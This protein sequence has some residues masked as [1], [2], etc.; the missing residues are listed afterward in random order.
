MRR[1]SAHIAVLS[2]LALPAWGQPDPGEALYGLGRQL[3]SEGKTAQALQKL[4]ESVRVSPK[5]PF[6]DDALLAAASIDYPPVGLN[7]LGR[8]TASGIPKARTRLE[9]IAKTYPDSSAAPA[10]M[11]RLGL[12]EM[13][14]V[15]P[16]ASLDEAYAT[17][18]QVGRLYP[19]SPEAAEAIYAA[20]TC[21]LLQG[22]RDAAAGEDARLV[23][24]HASGAAGE[25]ARLR[26]ATSA[27]RRGEMALAHRL[28]GPLLEDEIATTGS[29]NE[30][31]RTAS[32][33]RGAESTRAASVVRA[34]QLEYLFLRAAEDRPDRMGSR[35]LD[36]AFGAKSTAGESLAIA[37]GRDGRVWTLDD[38]SGRVAPLGGGG[39]QGASASA[40]GTTFAER[41][42][43][44][45]FDGRGA[46]VGWDEK[47][48][49]TR[50][51]QRLELIGPPARTDASGEPLRKI[52]AVAFGPFG[53]IDV[54]DGGETRVLRYGPDRAL[55]GVA[56]VLEGR[57][58]ALVRT[59][60]GTDYVLVAS[61]REV[62]VIPPA[63]APP[64]RRAVLPLKGP[65]WEL[66]SPAGLSVDPLGRI[67]VLDASSKSIAILDEQGRRVASIAPARG[68]PAE[69]KSPTAIAVDAAGYVYV[70]DRKPAR[71]VRF[72]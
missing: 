22:S 65:G 18:L 20:G 67:Y 19:R 70:A 10:A 2:L 66:G 3:L 27:A 4:E 34:K 37:V 63:G 46:L 48:L 24:E 49:L 5:G 6:A 52:T 15:N 14:P 35:V 60:D 55:K 56:A 12:L 39:G 44:F 23:V 40:E 11:F 64:S 7:D 59:D 72:K 57:P 58:T 36:D 38:D 29:S 1:T 62:H 41:P 31:E 17:F 61:R 8:A 30:G 68:T 28:L 25:R 71:I 45:G 51:G 13:D 53:E 32:P 21:L 47:G 54:A 16:R 9:T 43:G 26:L 42:R 33:D 50:D 69:L